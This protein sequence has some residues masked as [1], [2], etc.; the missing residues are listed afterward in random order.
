LR[1]FIIAAIDDDGPFT[2]MLDEILSM[3][4]CEVRIWRYAEGASDAIREWQPDL[5]ILDLWLDPYL[6]L[7]QMS[8]WRVLQELRDTPSTAEKSVILC[9][10]DNVSLNSCREILQGDRTVHCLTKP[11]ALEDL[12][13]QICKMIGRS[14][15]A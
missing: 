10:A 13:D 15:E 3:E 8:G 4:G 7:H 14:T 12:G 6:G 5:V 1:A 2:E 11:F 9:S